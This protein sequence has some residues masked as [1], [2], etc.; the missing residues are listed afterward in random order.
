MSNIEQNLQKILSSR[1]GKDVRQAI[2]DGI[3]DCYEDGKTGAVDLVAREQIANLVANT[4]S[5]EKD[6]EL[7]DVRVGSDGTA[8]TS[9]GEAVRE[10]FNIVSKDLKNILGIDINYIFNGF[11]NQD[12]E[13]KEHSSFKTTDFIE[14]ESDIY[15]VGNF[16][17]LQYPNSYVNFYDANKN[18][19]SSLYP[20]ENRV[21]T[22]INERIRKPDNA[23]YVRLT[24]SA[25]F[26]ESTKT[27]RLLKCAI[28]IDQL[29]NL[30]DLSYK[31]DYLAYARIDI[32]TV[33]KKINI[34]LNE[35][36]TSVLYTKTFYIYD[37]IKDNDD[38]TLSFD[39]SSDNYASETIILV[40]DKETNNFY[41]FTM[42]HYYNSEI[43]K[44]N[45][46]DL[47]V[48]GFFSLNSNKKITALKFYCNNVYIYGRDNNQNTT[49]LSNDFINGFGS[50]SKF[51]V[52]GDSLSVGYYTDSKGEQHG[53]DYDHSWGKYIEN[54]CSSKC[55]HLG[56]SGATC[57]SWLESSSNEWGLKYAQTI[58]ELPLY[59]ICMGANET[60]SNIG[61]IDD[62]NDDEPTSLYGYV[63]KTIRELRT[64]SPNCFIACTGISRGQGI[65]SSV[66]NVN[67]VYK[68]IC[69]ETEKCYYLDVMK[70]LNSYPFTNLYFNW[71]YSALGYSK[72]A[73]L[74]NNKLA[75]CMI[76][77]Y[78]DFIY[79]NEADQN[80]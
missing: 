32:D 2:H 31:A 26:L 40:Y 35:G 62:I 65:T 39:Y 77:N 59:I 49:A 67:N 51:G 3:H 42:Y 58:G 63:G 64:I 47:I 21:I 68:T 34:T 37:L 60:G 74:F 43:Y 29:K 57:K 36:G 48:F 55:F 1:Y 27:I 6:S 46:S 18:F 53:E 25:P 66:Q 5:T 71:H 50:F 14:I 76:N 22:S 72:L 7:V 17:D 80:A 11:I 61:T 69:E 16:R 24:N 70:E 19:V 44:H 15:L 41:I 23:E 75:D 28:D 12:G 52:V 56:K 20:G 10:Q 9:A 4:G 13:F 79:I 8:Y 38:I 30:L 73:S 45:T 54:I 33:S 78:E